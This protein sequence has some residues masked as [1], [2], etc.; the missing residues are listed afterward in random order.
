M[1]Y[2]N[3]ATTTDPMSNVT[4][5]YDISDISVMLVWPKSRGRGHKSEAETRTTRPRL[6]HMEMFLNKNT[7]RQCQ[8][9]ITEFLF[10][11]RLQNHVFIIII[12]QE[13]INVAFS[14]K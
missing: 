8:Q 6:G 2:S 9:H 11:I 4:C 3:I 10:H 7:W 12:I 5:R 1:L 13:K 14:P